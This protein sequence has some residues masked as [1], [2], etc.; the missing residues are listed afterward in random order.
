[1]QRKQYYSI[2]YN[3]YYEEIFYLFIF[4]DQNNYTHFRVRVDVT[5]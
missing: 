3:K 2:N 4:Y 5:L 1:M